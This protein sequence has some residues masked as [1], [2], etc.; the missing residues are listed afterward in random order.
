MERSVAFFEG[1]LSPTKRSL[2]PSDRSC[3]SPERP[4]E[5]PYQF[6]APTAKTATEPQIAP[7]RTPRVLSP[8]HHST[9]RLANSVATMN[10]TMDKS[11]VAANFE[12]ILN[13]L[14]AYASLWCA[15]NLSDAESGRSD[16]RSL[17]R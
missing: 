7:I 6:A 2:P 12:S 13:P 1:F 9:P 8:V 5:R 17:H 16:S 10:T 3:S 4:P 15:Q 11:T 14:A